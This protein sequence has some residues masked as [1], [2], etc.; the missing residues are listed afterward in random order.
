[1]VAGLAN[2]YDSRVRRGGFREADILRKELFNIRGGDD[3][4]SVTAFRLLVEM[5]SRYG[6]QEEADLW[7]E[8]ILEM[9]WK[10]ER[11]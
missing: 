10:E 2:W 7:Q 4:I 9:G 11:E 6:M 3:A 1:M 8:Y 5:Y